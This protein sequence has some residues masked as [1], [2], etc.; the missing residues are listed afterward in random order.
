MPLRGNKLKLT[1]SPRVTLGSWKN[2]GSWFVKSL[3]LYSNRL[4]SNL[5]SGLPTWKPLQT[6]L[7]YRIGCGWISQR[8]AQPQLS[9]LATVLRLPSVGTW[10]AKKTWDS[11]YAQGRWPCLQSAGPRRTA[12]GRLRT[13]ACDLICSHLRCNSLITCTLPQGYDTIMLVSLRNYFTKQA[14]ACCLRNRWW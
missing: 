9:V 12:I 8:A 7:L 10:R 11:P 5:S 1:T 2:S 4:W 3:L 13:A 6:Y 14:F